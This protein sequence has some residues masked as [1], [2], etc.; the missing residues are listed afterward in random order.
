MVYSLYDRQ[1]KYRK[2][3]SEQNPEFRKVE[4]ERVHSLI[5]KRSA[6]MTEEEKEE[7]RIQNREYMMSYRLK[8]VKERGKYSKD[9]PWSSPPRAE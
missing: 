2:R 7:K 8:K 6:L 9:Q 4:S 1:N 5:K 3:K